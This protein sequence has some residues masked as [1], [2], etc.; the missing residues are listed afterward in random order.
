MTQGRTEDF[1]EGGGS[2][3]MSQIQRYAIIIEQFLRIWR[4]GQLNMVYRD[5]DSILGQLYQKQ[6]CEDFYY[7]DF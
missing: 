4:L 1:S 7:D 3:N 2:R 5:E 6:I